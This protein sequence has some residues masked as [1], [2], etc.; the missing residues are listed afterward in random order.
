[1]RH[2]L[3]ARYW[4]RVEEFGLARRDWLNEY[5]ELP[6]RISDEKTFSRVFSIISASQLINTLAT[7]NGLILAV[8]K[9]PDKSNEIKCSG[10]KLWSDCPGFLGHDFNLFLRT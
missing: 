6:N 4:K 10:F 3:C 7:E 5:L 9:T 2:Y 1:M 8:E